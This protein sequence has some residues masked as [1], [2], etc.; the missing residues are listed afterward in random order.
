MPNINFSPTQGR[1]ADYVLNHPT[2]SPLKQ[3][4]ITFHIN[5]NYM[6][7]F[8]DKGIKSFV[9][10]HARDL[11]YQEVGTFVQSVASNADNLKGATFDLKDKE[12]GLYKKDGINQDHIRTGFTLESK[13]SLP[14]QGVVFFDA[15]KAT[16]PLKDAEKAIESAKEEVKSAQKTVGKAEDKYDHAVWERQQTVDFL[17]KK[18]PKELAEHQSNIQTQGVYLEELQEDKA[19]YQARL[20]QLEDEHNNQTANPPSGLD[21][22]TRWQEM[23][24]LKRAIRGIDLEIKDTQNSLNKSQESL[25]K[26]RGPLGF[27]GVGSS[28]DELDKENKEVTKRK[29]NLNDARKNLN[30][31]QEKL[32]AAQALRERILS[33]KSIAQPKPPAAPKP[34]VQPPVA[35]Q[36]AAP[37]PPVAEQPAQPPVAEQPA[38]PAEPPVAEQ[39]AQPPVADT[40]KPPPQTIAPGTPEPPAQPPVAEQPVAPAEPPVTPQPAQPPVADTPKPPPQSISP[41]QPHNPGVVNRPVGQRPAPVTPQPPAEP[42]VPQPAQPAHPPVQPAPRPAQPPVQQPAPVDLSPGSGIV[43][44]YTVQKGDT[45][46]SIAKNELGNWKRWTDIADMNRE[47]IGNQNHWIYPGQVL[48]LPPL[49]P[50]PAA[51]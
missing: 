8:T 18:A 7:D 36:P 30:K 48:R 15:T 41:G 1:V 17:G 47:V 5:G 37:K 38:A 31:A 28:L 13:S 50:Q 44:K 20:A 25:N 6:S 12:L 46:S 10:K 24:R 34:P 35:E 27:I 4:N 21:Q 16:H 49:Q 39:P 45:L 19:S 51:N 22:A 32:S 14:S 23:T 3:N 29:G 26:T 11:S 43:S 9:K 40:P 33:G 2:S 42:P